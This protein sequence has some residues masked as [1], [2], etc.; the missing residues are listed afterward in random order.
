M[1]MH[2]SV[3]DAM[4]NQVSEVDLLRVRAWAKDQLS[5]EAEHQP[6]STF[7]LTRLGE[8]IDALLAA[9]AAVRANG[10]SQAA[11]AETPLRLVISNAPPASKEGHD[12]ED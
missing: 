12:S 3:V 10:S 9:K 4:S 5:K 8:T 1:N 7:L 11:A 6:W 2:A